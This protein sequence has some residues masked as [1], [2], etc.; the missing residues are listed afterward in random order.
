LPRIMELSKVVA[1]VP[2]A[3][4]T[5]PHGRPPGGFDPPRVGGF[6]VPAASP[7]LKRRNSVPAAI[8]SPHSNG[9][10]RRDQLPVGHSYPRPSPSQ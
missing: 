5:K 7:S 4:D 10:Q 6:G 3:R 8:K 2:Q 9:S 1:D